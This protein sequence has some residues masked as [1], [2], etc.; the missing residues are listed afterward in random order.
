MSVQPKT[1]PF[2]EAAKLVE[3]HRAGKCRN[4]QL[5]FS[6]GY[7]PSGLPHIGTFGEVARTTM[8]MHAF[9]QLS[10]VP[11]KLICFSDDMDGMRKIPDNIPNAERLSAY[12]DQPLTSVPDPFGTHASYGEHMNARLCHF[13]DQFGF[14][15]EFYSATACY[16][17]GLFN[18]MLMRVAQRYDAIM[19]IML[20]TLGDE[21]KQTYS[22]FL[23]IS[24]TTG[25]ILYVSMKH[26]DAV[27][28]TITFEEEGR[29]VTIEVT[30][31][32]CKLQWKPDFG[33][34]WAALG[35]DFEMYGKDHLVNGKIYS[36]ICRVL[37]AEPPQQFN[38]ELFLDKDGQKI[39]KSKGNGLSLE[40]WLT[41]APQES[42][43]L[44]MYQSPSKA[45]R[46]HFDVIPKAVD[47]YMAYLRSY[48]ATEDELARL[49]NPVWVIHGG[50]VP[51]YE[52]IGISFSLLLNLASACN[53][54]DKGV[55]WGFISRMVKGV[56]AED[57]PLLDR[58]THYA[59]RYYHDVVKPAKHY[60]S[61]AE[62]RE[63]DALD[64]L[65]HMLEGE[66]SGSVDAERLQE[67][68]YA[69][70]REYYGKEQMREWFACMYETLLGAS[71]GPRMGSFI[72]LYG[73]Q[74]TLQ[75]IHEACARV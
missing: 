65:A 47:E 10:D 18:E 55:L 33:M 49:D 51:A 64:A 22:P 19:K 66:L 53:P 26:V 1:W 75:L 44:Y 58:L 37:G 34:R 35:V 38:Y 14:E 61:V 42:L 63:R 39:S 30:N 32:T 74:E 12:I 20:P 2:V 29:D 23:P 13:L 41:Y 27:A 28:G 50:D 60:R 67:A 8:V 24:P 69:I 5:I 70:G 11:I 62:G 68:I 9:R 36:A 57:Y 3:R 7:G 25:K 21:R 40:E 46:L 43:S 17:S 56:C 15:Y 54:E 72:A 6:T 71:Q 48:H 16:R 31:G 73:T 45:K 4:A 59:V 52:D